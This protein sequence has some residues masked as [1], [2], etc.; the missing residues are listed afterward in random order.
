MNLLAETSSLGADRGALDLAALVRETVAADAVRDVLHLRL[1]ALAPE[2]RQPRHLRQLRDVL[3]A[4]LDPA[5]AR[6]FE[7]PNGDVVAVARPPA[8]VLD[9]AVAA[10]HRALDPAPAPMTRRLRL[11]D[12]AA[13]LL[14]TAAES[15]GLEPGA[16]TE[17]LPAA[18][19]PP[20][21]SAGLAATERALAAADLSSLTI[22]QPVC[23][24]APEGGQP[25]PLW[26]D[27][28]IDWPALVELLLPGR[29][30]S[31]APG[32]ARRLA[33]ATE[34]RLLI[35]LGRPAAQAEWRPVGLA[36]AP[37]LI[38]SAAFDRFAAGLPTGRHAEL[39]IALRPADL[40][41][42]TGAAARILPMLR[43]RGFRI[44]LDD[45]APGFLALLPPDRLGP[46][47][48][49]R[50]RWSLTLPITQPEPLR[51]L[52]AEAPERVALTGVDRPAAIAWGWEA[53]LRL[54][55]GPL[56]ERRRRGI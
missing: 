23:R 24:L 53:G 20:L 22:G 38:E 6:I 48:L 29:D 49:V 11:P 27:R 17:E 5:R 37:A 52:L 14:N 15:L 54:F 51:R 19:R 41:A 9:Q 44:A 32:L 2:L 35:E 21:C 36:L 7:L 42:D 10:L 13:Q 1:G 46:D 50:L 40:L 55:Q 28:R 47:V 39:T 16:T 3:A 4:V 26:E 56:V 34:A 30:L 45:A 18:A 33:R 43:R 25:E 12:D 8:A 31:A